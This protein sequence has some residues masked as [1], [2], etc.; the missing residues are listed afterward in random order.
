MERY[1]EIFLASALMVTGE[2]DRAIE[3]AD[4]AAETAT[5]PT[6]KGRALLVQADLRR[7]RGNLDGAQEA[8]EA[9]IAAAEASGDQ[10]LPSVV[11]STAFQATEE[12][13]RSRGRPASIR[14]P[15]I[16][17]PL[18]PAKQSKYAIFIS[19]QLFPSNGHYMPYHET[20]L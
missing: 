8:F 16:M 4:G 9:S 6:A 18:A 12:S 3:L 1:L 5:S 2:W 19:A 15:R 10:E 14:A 17:S 11:V 7:H 13:E 20:F